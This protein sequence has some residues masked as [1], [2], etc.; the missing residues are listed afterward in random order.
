MKNPFSFPGFFQPSWRRG[1]LFV[2]GIFACIYA[3][4]VLFYVQFIPDLGLKSAFSP[5]IK[6]Q[7]RNFQPGDEGILP[8]EGDLVVAV[9]DM[10]V[11]TWP[12]LLIAPFFMQQKLAAGVSFP[13]EK[14]NEETGQ[15]YILIRFERVA[16]E[17]PVV[18]SSWG[19][20][21][22]L[23][24]EDLLPSVLWFFL[25]IS[26][27]AVGALVFWK[28]PSDAA[29]TQFFILCIATLCAFMGGYHWPYILTQPFLLLVFM[30]AAIFLPM[31][32]LHFYLVFPRKK[33]WLEHHPGATLLS[34]YAIPLLFLGTL[35]TLYYRLRWLA[36]TGQPTADIAD[37]SYTIRDVAYFYLAVATIAYLASVWA[38]FHSFGTA[39]D[40]TERNQVK[41]IFLGAVLALFPIGYSLYLTFWNPDA[42]AAGAATWPMF[43]ASACL[44]VAFA[45][46]ITR[47]RLLELDQIISSSVSYFLISFL[48]GL[49]YY[50]VVF[51]GTLVFNQVIASP[52]LSEALTVSATALLLM[53][54]LDRARTRFQKALDKRFSRDKSQ[55]DKTLQQ[56]G[57][58][59]QQLVDPPA[60]AQR[61]L[62]TASELLGVRRGAIFL[63]EWDQPRYCQAGTVGNT[64]SS[65]ELAADCPLL[66][67][68]HVNPVIRVQSRPGTVL[69]PGQRQLQLLGG[70]LALALTHE[71]HL[72]AVLIL[73]PKLGEPY[74][75]EDLSLLG[76]LTQIA[77]LALEN[78][79]GHRIMEKLNHD[80]RAKV[81]KISEQQRRILALQSQ[82]RR[83]RQGDGQVNQNDGQAPPLPPA[84]NGEAP[85]PGGI[86]GS[87]PPIRQLLTLIRKVAST[88]AVVL[89]RGESGTGKELLARAIHETSAR[90]DQAFVKVHCAALSA[91][92]LESELFGHVKGAFTGAHRDKVGR[93][94]LANKGTL[95]LDEIGDISLEVQTKLLR[96]L[97]ERTFERVGSSEPITVDVRIITATHQHLEELMRQG[98]FREDLFYRLNVFPIVVP[99]L[100]ERLEDIPELAMFFMHQSAQR[101]RKEVTQLDDDVLAVLKAYSWPG[102]IRQLE[103]VMERAVVIAEGPVVTVQELPS[104][105]LLALEQLEFPPEN[106]PAA[107]TDNA[108]FQSP[109]RQERDRFEREQ[110]LRA[111]TAAGGNKAEAARALGIARSTLVSRLKKFGIN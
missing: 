96:V 92:L 87:S 2:L 108:A 43:T 99:P 53:L 103:N 97:Q 5:A 107:I 110:L 55:L 75:P 32:S 86:V 15:T 98:R 49:L 104:D 68:L 58:A 18:F 16:S 66:T 77:A 10:A 7:P 70:E 28:R 38:L 89:I 34:L 54:V 63:H 8:Q 100:R 46:S 37:I 22:N 1:L 93:F 51:L 62:Q 61:L 94:E 79:E 21:D 44:T 111:L 83:Q 20:L 64:M 72:L 45:V 3:F 109:L 52:K 69:T 30:V 82:L 105:M 90:A 31:V 27:F 60:L 19:L 74:R 85:S 13:W 14:I 23:P 17:N 29:A 59:I 76:A 26:L 91:G 95:F 39:R 4:S 42:F 80:L 88:E 78:A 57:Q 84:P 56:M 24:L 33:S 101:C 12:D 73:G 106:W 102:N 81:E 6:G 67:E 71:G 50:G 9:G 25:K 65:S 40:L 11:R 48:A 41:W 35:V 47:Y 36:Q